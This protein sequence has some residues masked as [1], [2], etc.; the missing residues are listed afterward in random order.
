MAINKE[1]KLVSRADL[2]K[3]KSYIINVVDSNMDDKCSV[4]K[5]EIRE[6]YKKN[7]ILTYL[8]YASFI[9]S[10]TLWGATMLSGTVIW[11]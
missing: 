11:N 4:L 2:E 10:A 5:T 3:C 6:M 7:S 9:V 1:E 8:V